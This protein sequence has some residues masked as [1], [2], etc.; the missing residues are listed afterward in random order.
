[1]VEGYTKITEIFLYKRG[2]K[3]YIEY[4]LLNE[5]ET[6]SKAMFYNAIKYNTVKDKLDSILQEYIL[7]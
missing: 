6:A 2:K 3:Y 1:M 7:V 4:L 5:E